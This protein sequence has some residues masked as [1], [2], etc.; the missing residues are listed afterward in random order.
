MAA[1]L[2]G[3]RTRRHQ[4]RMRLDIRVLQP[5]HERGIE[6]GKALAVVEIVEA[7]P[8]ASEGRAQAHSLSRYPD[9]ARGELF[10]CEPIRQARRT[11]QGGASFATLMLM[12]GRLASRMVR[13]ACNPSSAS[14]AQLA[15]R[16]GRHDF[17]HDRARRAHAADRVRPV[18]GRMEAG[19]RLAAA[20]RRSG[21]AGGAAEISFLAA[22]PIG[23]SWF[24]RRR[25]QADLLARV[26]A[27][28]VGPSDRPRRRPAARLVLAARPAL[29]G[30]ASRDCLPCWCWAACRARWAG[31][32]SPRAWSTAPRSA[33]TGSPPICCSPIALYAYTVWLVLELGRR[34]AATIPRSAARRPA[35]IAFLL[36]VMTFGALMAGLRAG[37]RAQHL[38]H[39][40]GLLDPARHVRPVA[41]VDQPVRERHDRPVHPSLARQAPGAGRAGAG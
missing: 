23:E 20:A 6:A 27:P 33:T 15:D 18:D 21:V 41:V 8:V 24:R 34:R 12:T 30:A 39:H 5:G 19:H 40:V 37:T 13:R 35:L 7:Q 25:I 31:R 32:W 38:S 28:S 26:P 3:C 9:A 36:V 2:S 4:P 22:G 11:A 14:V 10:V 1:S 16:R 17:F 29:A